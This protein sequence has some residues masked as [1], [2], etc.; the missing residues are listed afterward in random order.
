MPLIP[1]NC[2]LLNILI[3]SNMK[4]TIQRVPINIVHGKIADYL[5]NWSD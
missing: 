1:T 5:K 3:F 4:G 2:N